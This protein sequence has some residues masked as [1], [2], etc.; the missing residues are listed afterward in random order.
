MYKKYVFSGHES[1][2]C[3]MLWPIKG[4]DYIVEG[5][6]FNDSNSVVELGVGK[7]M[8]AS[9]RYWLKVLGLTEQDKLTSIANYLFDKENGKDRCNALMIMDVDYFKQVNDTYG[10]MVGDKVLKIFGRLLAKQ[11]REKDIVGR[12]GGDEFMVLICNIKDVEIAKD[13]AKKL[14]NEVRA[15]QIP[16]LA[17]A[18]LPS[19]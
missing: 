7:N 14:I 2:P 19:V 10:H 3:R 11:F 8:V 16:E 13:R 9:I 17:E 18:V 15:L 1:F 4:Y 5:N 6:N 12:I